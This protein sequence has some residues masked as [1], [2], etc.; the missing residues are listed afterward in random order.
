MIGR[1]LLAATIA[2]I[3]I[4]DSSS[5]AFVAA[6]RRHGSRSRTGRRTDWSR[7]PLDDEVRVLRLADGAGVGV[8]P[9]TASGFVADGLAYANDTRLR[10]IPFDQLPL[11]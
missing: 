1:F 3:G 10:L 9:G 7:T 2:L 11:P 4:A 6:T 8:G 5:G